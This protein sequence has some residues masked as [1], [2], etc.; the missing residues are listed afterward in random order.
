MEAGGHHQL[1]R[2]GR[3]AGGRRA[4]HRGHGAPAQVPQA[5]STW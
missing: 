2:A 3:G 4:D 5:A 1:L